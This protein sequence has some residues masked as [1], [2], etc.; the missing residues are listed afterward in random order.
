MK[1]DEVDAAQLK[2]NLIKRLRE[3]KKQRVTIKTAYPL[4]AAE[5]KLFTTE[6]PQLK[7]KEVINEVNPELLGGFVIEDDEGVID[8]S[9]L[10]NL[11]AYQS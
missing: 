6:L 9:I 5:L 8:M 10:G 2:K 7:E 1:I 11:E 4:D 3:I